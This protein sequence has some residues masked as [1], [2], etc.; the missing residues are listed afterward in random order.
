MKEDFEVRVTD[1]GVQVGGKFL[2]HNEHLWRRA[3]NRHTT[4][5]GNSWGWVAYG[6]NKKVGGSYWSNDRGENFTGKMATAAVTAHNKWLEDIQPT[7]IKV[8]KAKR[9]LSKLQ[10]QLEEKKFSYEKTKE[11]YEEACKELSELLGENK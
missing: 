2:T 9:M 8:I 1:E 11:L 3:T 5:Y 6:D 4:I 10:N 7:Q